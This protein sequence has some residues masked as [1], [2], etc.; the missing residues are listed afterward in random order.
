MGFQWPIVETPGRSSPPTRLGRTG[1]DEK[2]A[3]HEGSRT[4]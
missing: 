1:I 4:E 3:I 2:D